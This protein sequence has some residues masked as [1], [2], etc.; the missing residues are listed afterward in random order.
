[1]CLTSPFCGFCVFLFSWCWFKVFLFL[2]ENG[3]MMLSFLLGGY[4]HD[5]YDNQRDF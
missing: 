4:I 2:C 3:I 1:M 5:Q